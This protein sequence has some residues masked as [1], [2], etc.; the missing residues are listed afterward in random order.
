M[1]VQERYATFFQDEIVAIAGAACE[2][3][4]SENVGNIIRILP[5]CQAAIK[6]VKAFKTT[7]QLSSD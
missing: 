1:I 6:V 5:D 4:G 7:K 2:L 3:L